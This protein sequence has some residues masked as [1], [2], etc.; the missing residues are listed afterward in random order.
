MPFESDPSMSSPGGR[1]GES[2]SFPPSVA[3]E[4]RFPQTIFQTYA[5]LSVECSTAPRKVW[6][7][8][9]ISDIFPNWTMEMNEQFSGRPPLKFGRPSEPGGNPPSE[10]DS[11]KGRRS[12]LGSWTSCDCC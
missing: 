10:R 12:E 3:R 2:R 7:F 9:M 11:S 4:P 8:L 6:H 1:A 5:E